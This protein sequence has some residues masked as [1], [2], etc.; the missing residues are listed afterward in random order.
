VT[1]KKRPRG[2]TLPPGMA[3]GLTVVCGLPDGKL[4]AHGK[5]LLIVQLVDKDVQTVAGTR[6]PAGDGWFYTPCRKHKALLMFHEDEIRKAI[7]SGEVT[8]PVTKFAPRDSVLME[9]LRKSHTRPKRRGSLRRAVPGTFGGLAEKSAH[10]AT[11]VSQRGTR[12]PCH[13]SSEPFAVASGGTRS[14]P[15]STP[16]STLRRLVRPS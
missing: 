13:P 2:A 16:E 1:V 12:W 5:P 11:R 9:Y 14:T 3:R 8:M 10:R 6:Y 15:R 4:R 7:K